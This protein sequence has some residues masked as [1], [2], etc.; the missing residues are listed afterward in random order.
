MP[1]GEEEDIAVRAEAVLRFFALR[2][3]RGEEVTTIS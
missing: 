2:A 3:V 1:S